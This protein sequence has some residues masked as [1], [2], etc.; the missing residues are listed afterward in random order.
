[1]NKLKKCPFC[2]SQAELLYLS[3]SYWVQ[4]DNCFAKTAYFKKISH[5]VSSWNIRS[6]K[7]VTLEDMVGKKDSANNAV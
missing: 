6:A 3:Y 1:M 7:K 2:K 4:C 5:A